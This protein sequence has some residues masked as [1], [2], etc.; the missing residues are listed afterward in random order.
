M[1]SISAITGSAAAGPGAAKSSPSLA[2]DPNEFLQLFVAELKNQDPTK[3]MDTSQL[4]QQMSSMSQVE[5]A[6]QTNA[7]L[8]SLLDQFT[9]GQAAGMVGLTVT[10]ADGSVS[11]VVQSV[12][13]SSS[14]LVAG[15]ADGR[16]LTIE[17]GV[18][19]ER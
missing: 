8:A 13:T 7:K 6:V 2:L 15:L 3:P 4:V 18:T 12:R 5:Q 11:G 10:S 16:S 17:P 14:G 9:I 1:T 19:I